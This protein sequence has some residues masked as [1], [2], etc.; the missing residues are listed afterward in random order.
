MTDQAKTL[1]IDDMLSNYN[2]DGLPAE[3]DGLI[4]SIEQLRFTLGMADETSMLASIFLKMPVT[5]ESRAFLD[6]VVQGWQAMDATMG[7]YDYLSVIAWDWN[8]PRHAKGSRPRAIAEFL[9]KIH[10]MGVRFYDAESGDCWGPC[11]L[12]YYVASRVL[13]DI[14]EAG[15]VEEIIDD[16]LNK[17]FGNKS[18]VSQGNNAIAIDVGSPSPRSPEA[19]T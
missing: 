4:A 2:F 14:D 13:W 8:L 17:S 12:G 1:V 3:A 15:R 11:G 16:F 5:D 9:P 10:K 18:S 6:Q 19:G 7:C